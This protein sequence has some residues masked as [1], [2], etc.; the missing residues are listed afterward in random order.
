MT[1]LASAAMAAP[2][3]AAEAPV[4]VPLQGLEPAIPMDAPTV[5]TG[6]PLL[7]PG[8]PTG[9]HPGRAG[10]LPDVGVP[11]VPLDTTL[12]ESAVAAPLPEVVDGSELGQVLF[13]APR[14]KMAAATPGA[15]VGT[16]ITQPHADRFGMP[17]LTAPRAGVIAPAVTGTLD[18]QLGLARPTA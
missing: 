17:G 1:A 7:I 11:G 8:G 12:P 9:F 18:S 4:I 15:V 3:A 13:T 2:A 10:E 16:P 6:V 5:A 14:S